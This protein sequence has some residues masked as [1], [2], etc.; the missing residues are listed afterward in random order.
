MSALPM[1]L[2]NNWALL[3]LLHIITVGQSECPRMPLID[4]ISNKHSN[5]S[6][7]AFYFCIL[8]CI[9][10]VFFW[11]IFKHT[12]TTQI[13]LQLQFFNS[14]ISSWFCNFSWYFG[15][16]IV[17]CVVLTFTKQC[18]FSRKSLAFCLMYPP[19]VFFLFCFFVFCFASQIV[20]DLFSLITHTHTHTHTNHKT[21]IQMLL[22]MQLW[23]NLS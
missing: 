22:T 8:F 16:Q 20:C 2:C 23:Y 11:W 18:P 17:W 10:W 19:F 1:L 9:L 15:W 4:N 6:V 12:H 13:W 3:L 21:P 5:L 14:T 7:S